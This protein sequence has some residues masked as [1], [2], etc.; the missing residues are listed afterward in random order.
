MI[1]TRG[2]PFF[3]T[4]AGVFLD[5]PWY[6]DVVTSAAVKANSV[7]RYMPERA[8][9]IAPHMR[10]RLLAICQAATTLD[11]VCGIFTELLCMYALRTRNFYQITRVIAIT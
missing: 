2:V 8:G 3:R 6:G 5:A 9:E 10:T 7:Y 11:N 4:H 1:V